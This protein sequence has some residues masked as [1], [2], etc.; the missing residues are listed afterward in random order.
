MQRQQ[1]VDR[2]TM[3]SDASG[4]GRRLGPVRVPQTRV[5]GAEVVDGANPRHPVLKRQRMARH[6]SA[7]TRQWSQAFTTRGVEPFDVGGIDYP[8]P[9]RAASER[10]DTRGGPSTACPPRGHWSLVKVERHDNGLER[11]A[12]GQKRHDTGP[13]LAR[14]P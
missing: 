13:G 2:P 1:F 3:I 8:V 14:D 12:V 11:T 7:S 5:Q 4:H 6:S 10:L 9:V